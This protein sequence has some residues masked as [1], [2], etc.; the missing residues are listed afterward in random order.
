MTG[1]N[2]PILVLKRT[3]GHVLKIP[4]LKKKLEFQDCEKSI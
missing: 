4:P 2:T 3:L 1:E